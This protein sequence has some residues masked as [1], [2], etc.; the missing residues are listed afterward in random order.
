MSKKERAGGQ[1]HGKVK[2]SED[3]DDQMSLDDLICT[4]HEA[5]TVKELAEQG[6]TDAE[7]T[8]EILS[9]REEALVK[10]YDNAL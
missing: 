3:F 6:F 1:W 7:I 8:H 5:Q 10:D 2:V 4:D 9:E